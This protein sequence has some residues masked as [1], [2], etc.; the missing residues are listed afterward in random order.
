VAIARALVADPTMLLADE[1]TGALDSETSHSVLRLFSEINA[2]GHTVV[3]ITHEAQV[4]A[5][6]KRIVR[7]Q[8]GMVVG[9]ERRAGLDDVPPGL[10]P[11]SPASRRAA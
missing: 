2:H 7:L 6:A 3:V 9:D 8:D 10:Y 5:Y 4:A 1:P 11:G